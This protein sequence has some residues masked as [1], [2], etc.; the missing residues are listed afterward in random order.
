M[1]TG[2]GSPCGPGP[3]STPES[4]SISGDDEGTLTLHFDAGNLPAGRHTGTV[5]VVTDDVSSPLMV[6]PVELTVRY[7]VFLPLIKR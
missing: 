3:S 4:G 6:I 1:T 7:Q 2:S 5:V